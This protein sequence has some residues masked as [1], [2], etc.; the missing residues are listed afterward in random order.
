MYI[1]SIDP[2]NKQSAYVVYDPK[3]LRILKHGIVDNHDL[4]NGLLFVP[5]GRF[6]IEMVAC[7]GMPVGQEVFETVLWI[8]RFMQ[9]IKDYGQ[10]VS[11]VYRKDVKMYFCG[12]MKAKDSNIRQAL[13]DAYGPIGC[14]KEPGPLYGIKKDEWSAL[15]IALYFNFILKVTK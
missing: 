13:I 3:Q 12:S 5:N 14:K 4:V 15:A 7:Y 1:F 2:G 8:G 9:K 10:E 11:L 6:V